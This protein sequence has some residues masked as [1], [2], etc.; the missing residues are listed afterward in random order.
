MPI[1]TAGVHMARCSGSAPFTPLT[2]SFFGSIWIKP[3]SIMHAEKSCRPEGLHDTK[4]E[5]CCV[6]S[7]QVKTVGRAVGCSRCP[8]KYLLSNDGLDEACCGIPS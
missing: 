7:W 3:R 4:P 5:L 2:F 1:P 8:T 6:M